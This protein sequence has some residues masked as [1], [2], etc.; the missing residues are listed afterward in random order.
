MPMIFNTLS[1]RI[2]TKY[3]QYVSLD[4]LRNSFTILLVTPKQQYINPGTV[5]MPDCNTFIDKRDLNK[6]KCK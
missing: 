6:T 3:F 1:S 4:K 5:I 2:V